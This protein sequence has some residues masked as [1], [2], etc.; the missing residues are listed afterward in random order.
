MTVIE[1]S[2]GDLLAEKTDALVNAV[3]CVGNMGAGIALQFKR[4]WPENFRAYAAACR[5]GEVQPGR[6]FIFETRQLAPPRYI[7]NFPTKRHW[8]GNS[9]MEDI[10]AGLGALVAVIPRLGLDSIAVPALGAGLGGLPWN[11]VRVRIERALEALPGLRV[12]VF[13]PGGTLE[14]SG[15]R[16]A[17][18]HVDCAGHR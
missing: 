6:M 5:N 8:R 2:T 12:V 11:E 1:Y 14:H 18:Q 3:N 9:R 16:R 17:I 7:V 4:A 10:D 15:S 13:E